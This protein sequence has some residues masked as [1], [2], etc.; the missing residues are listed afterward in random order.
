ME[1]AVPGTHLCGS[2]GVSR[3]LLLVLCLQQLAWN[4]RTAGEAAVGTRAAAAAA[5][6]RGAV[7][8]APPG[9]PPHSGLPAKPLP[10]PPAR[11]ASCPSE[12]QRPGSPLGE[13]PSAHA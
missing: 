10:P 12:R 8:P 4:D 1:D 9:S 6:G 3:L 5:S 7:P 13:V 11:P 2:V